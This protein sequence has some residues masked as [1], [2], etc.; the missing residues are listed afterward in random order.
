MSADKTSFR[1]P[2]IAYAFN[3]NLR[4]HIEAHWSKPTIIDYTKDRKPW[5]IPPEADLLMSFHAGWTEAPAEAPPGWPFNLRQIQVLTAGV[6]KYPD[7]ALNAVP[8]IC[9]RGVS[10]V[11]IAEY[12]VTAIVAYDKKWSQ[13][14]TMKKGDPNPDMLRISNRSVGLVGVGAIGRE[15]AI[16]ANA[17]GMTV[18]GYTRSGRAPE[19]VPVEMVGSLEELMATSDHVL[20]ATPLTPE[21]RGMISAGVLAAAKPGLHFINVARGEIVDQDALLKALDDGRIGFATL[22]V[23]TPEP[24][25]DGHP[26]EQHPNV[27]IT[28][29]I[30]WLTEENFDR[31]TDKVMEDLDRYARGEPPVNVVDPSAKY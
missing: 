27:L 26:L 6:D 23:T 11:P 10:A 15:V 24:L 9:G 30:S 17:F 21:T 16:R 7:W 3:D 4:K 12:A 13:L 20:I 19:G 14:A 25:P 28:P 18:R 22:D 1:S 29:H 5:D 31:L 8:T 2:V